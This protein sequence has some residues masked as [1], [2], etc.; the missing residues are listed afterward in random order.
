MDSIAVLKQIG[1]ISEQGLDSDALLKIKSLIWTD[2]LELIAQAIEDENQ[3]EA[4]YQLELR[5]LQINKKKCYQAL[6]DLSSQVQSGVKDAEKKLEDKKNELETISD[7]MDQTTFLLEQGFKTGKAL[8]D[9]LFNAILEAVYLSLKNAERDRVQVVEDI[10]KLRQ[11]VKEKWTLKFELDERIKSMNTYIG[12]IL[13]K[14]Q[15]DALDQHFLGGG[16]S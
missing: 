4:R 5:H 10:D 14:D 15:M 12:S 8:K 3:L 16:S 11:L 9:Q 6:L 2:D 7:L 13:T 1:L